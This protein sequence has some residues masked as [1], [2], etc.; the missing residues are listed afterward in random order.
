MTKVAMLQMASRACAAAENRSRAL[1]AAEEAFGMGAQVA[2]LPELMV[3]G[4]TTDKLAAASVAE[5]LDGA[6][7]QAFRKLAKSAGGLVIFGM[8]E[9]GTGGELY[10]TVVGVAGDGIIVHYR[11][12]HLFA[13]ERDCY[14]PGDLGLPVVATPWGI[15][16]VCVCYD[17]RFVEVLRILSLRGAE[18]VVAPA[19]WVHGFDQPA[20]AEGLPAQAKGAVVQANLDQVAVVAVS[21]VGEGFLGG[22]VACGAF[23][24]L[25]A[26]PLSRSREEVAI[27]DVS[28][29]EVRSSYRRAPDIMPRAD[30]RTDVYGLHW[31]DQR[32]EGV[33]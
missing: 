22:S 27:A 23:G 8:C 5:N 28:L 1:A 26:G 16:G 20:A 19:A 3:S 32:R 2:V 30:R 18:I 15:L 12:L 24:N 31:R 4:Y 11:K 33:L 6:S 7:V 9:R 13:A 17:L 25:L 21:Q 14:K 10:N 29:A